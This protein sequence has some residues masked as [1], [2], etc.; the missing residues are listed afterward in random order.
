MLIYISHSRHYDYK[1]ELYQPIRTSS[2]NDEHT[3]ILPHEESDEPFSSKDLLESG[4]CHLMLAEVSFP[5]TGQGIELGWADAF[6]VPI[7]CIYKLDTKV[8]QSLYVVSNR[9]IEYLN[10]DDMVE[11][12]GKVLSK[13]G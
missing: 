13:Y 7:V 4:E 6:H 9:F 1:N 11:K 12:V 8:P 5:S 10:A 2:L 3:F